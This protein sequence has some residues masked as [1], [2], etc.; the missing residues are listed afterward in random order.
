MA[1]PNDT[2]G[3][4]RIFAAALSEPRGTLWAWPPS[5]ATSSGRRALAHA[6]ASPACGPP[7]RARHLR[8]ACCLMLASTSSGTAHRFSSRAPIPGRSPSSRGPASS[9]P[10][11]GSCPAGHPGSLVCQPASSS[12][13]AFRSPTYGARLR[14]TAWPIA[15]PPPPAPWLPPAFWITRSPSG[16][17]RRSRPTR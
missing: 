3:A 11:C 12:T 10:G 2:A 9:S 17:A 1:N 16:L 5:S 4:H 6:A 7:G 14:P 8:G 13:G 15:S